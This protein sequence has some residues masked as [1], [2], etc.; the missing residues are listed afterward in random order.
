M[1]GSANAGDIFAISGLSGF[2]TY[3]RTIRAE[4]AKIIDDYF[5]MF[6]YKVNALKVPNI[7]GRKS[8]N[9]VKTID[10]VIV[11]NV[12]VD[13]MSKLKNIFNKGVTFWHGDW[14]GDYERDN[15]N[16]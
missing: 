4:Y 1:S 5:T 15:T 12:P 11:G 13:A 9:Y 3:C 14:V 2:Y 8:F 6:G 7:Y 10:A 16:A